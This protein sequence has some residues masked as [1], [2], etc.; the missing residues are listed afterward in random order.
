MFTRK[1]LCTHLR[2]IQLHV[3]LTG[4]L[5]GQGLLRINAVVFQFHIWP[6]LVS[7]VTRVT[8]RSGKCLEP[9]LQP[10]EGLLPCEELLVLEVELLDTGADGEERRCNSSKPRIRSTSTPISTVAC[11]W[12]G[13]GLLSSWESS[14][15]AFTCLSLLVETGTQGS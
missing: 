4:I 14:D 12:L 13:K 15:S 9:K 10:W 1:V 2:R 5:H 7:G 3:R 8:L 6:T 11:C